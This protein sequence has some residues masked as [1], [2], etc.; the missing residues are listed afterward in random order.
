MKELMKILFGSLF[1]WFVTDCLI[2]GMIL[3]IGNFIRLISNL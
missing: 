1:V 2:E 3:N